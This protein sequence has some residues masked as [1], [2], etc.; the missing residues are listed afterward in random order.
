[1]KTKQL[2]ALVLVVVLACV[3]IGLSVSSSGSIDKDSI[4]LQSAQFQTTAM[5][6]ATVNMLAVGDN[7]IH[8]PI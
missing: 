3:G 6:M 5:R 1:M 2:I 7:L 4:E 8:K